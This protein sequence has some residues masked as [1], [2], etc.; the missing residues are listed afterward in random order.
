MCE[1][2]VRKWN[3]LIYL[4]QALFYVKFSIIPL[5]NITH[6]RDNFTIIKRH[7][8]KEVAPVIKEFV[9]PS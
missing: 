7:T 5:R 2:N 1:F 6:V 4:L 8:F 3:A 9:H